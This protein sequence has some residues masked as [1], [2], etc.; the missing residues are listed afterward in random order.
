MASMKAQRVASRH[1]TANAGFLFCNALISDGISIERCSWPRTLDGS[2]L[3]GA[4][5]RATWT[6]DGTRSDT[7]LIPFFQFVIAGE[8]AHRRAARL[9]KDDQFRSDAG[10]SRSLHRKS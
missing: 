2:F 5:S 1:S 9:P 4:P 7:A 3:R 10:S 8:L 6:K